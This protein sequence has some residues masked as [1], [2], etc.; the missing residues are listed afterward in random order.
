MFHRGCDDYIYVRQGDEW[1]K[2]SEKKAWNMSV[3]HNSLWIIDFYSW[4]LKSL[5][6]LVNDAIQV[7]H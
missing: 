4:M 1:Q 2:F 7:R 5:V 6:I 3:S